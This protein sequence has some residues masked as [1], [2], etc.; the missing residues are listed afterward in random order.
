M[1]GVESRLNALRE[2][3]ELLLAEREAV[4]RRIGQLLDKLDLLSS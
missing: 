1:E 4:A 3:N 2:E